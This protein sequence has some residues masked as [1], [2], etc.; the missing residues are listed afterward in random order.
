M[1]KAN[2]HD[3]GKVTL[4]VLANSLDYCLLLVIIAQ[5]LT[6]AKDDLFF[7][8]GVDWLLIYT[9]ETR[10]ICRMKIK[11]HRVVVGL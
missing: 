3:S 6:H 10:L 1:S 7:I 4:T 8:L 11:N 2:L 5:F 9:F